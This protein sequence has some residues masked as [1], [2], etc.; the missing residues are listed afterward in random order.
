MYNITDNQNEFS[1]A[2]AEM[3]EAYKD[4]ASSSNATER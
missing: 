1:Q 4:H 3:A 2:S